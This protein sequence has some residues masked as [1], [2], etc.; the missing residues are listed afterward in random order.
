M[1]YAATIPST[2]PGSSA[3]ETP[4][5]AR[6]MPSSVRKLTWRSRTSSSVTPR[7]PRSTAGA[8]FPTAGVPGLAPRRAPARS[9]ALSPMLGPYGLHRAPVPPPPRRRL[10]GAPSRAL[11][12]RP[13]RSSQRRARPSPGGAGRARAGAVRSRR[14]RRRD[15]RAPPWSSPC[16]CRCR[17]RAPRSRR[18]EALP[19]RGRR[20][21]RAE[22][23]GRDAGELGGLDERTTRSP[24][25]AS[26]WLDGK[27]LRKSS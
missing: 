1:V 24:A 8:P 17:G 26:T 15:W 6:T 22:H 14:S 18:A 13:T 11:A 23:D 12:G 4:L 21:A 25:L 5:T 7:A 9:P 20:G 19:D 2:S 16:R 10:G 27:T 3:N